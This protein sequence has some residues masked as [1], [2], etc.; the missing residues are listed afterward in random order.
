MSPSRKSRKSQRSRRP[1]RSQASRRRRSRQQRTK[2][3]ATK[4]SK[5]HQRGGCWLGDM[6]WG[7]GKKKN[8]NSALSPEA[9]LLKEKIKK[10]QME[11]MNKWRLGV[12][13]ERYNMKNFLNAQELQEQKKRRNNA[14]YFASAPMEER[15]QWVQN[16]AAR[17]AARKAN[18]AA[19]EAAAIASSQPTQR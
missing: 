14:A 13:Q 9:L 12:E 3:S 2:K 15:P 10:K 8:V 6:L 7:D 19:Y 4:K 11:N 18:R 17:L 1:R 5:T 16:N